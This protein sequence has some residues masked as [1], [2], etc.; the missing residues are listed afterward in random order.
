MKKKATI[1]YITIYKIADLWYFDDHL[2]QIEKEGFV[3]STS[4]ILDCFIKDKDKRYN[5][6]FSSS[7]FP[8][9]QHIARWVLGGK[10]GNFYK[11]GDSI[12]WLCRVLYRYFKIAPLQIYFNIEAVE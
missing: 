11:M 7:K 4:L 2:R 6:V 9:Y 1:F 12:G 8:S 3:L 10:D 5:I